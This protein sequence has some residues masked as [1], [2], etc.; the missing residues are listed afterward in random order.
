MF[1]RAEIF[2]RVRALYRTKVYNYMYLIHSFC[3][4]QTKKSEMSV[5]RF[6]FYLKRTNSLKHRLTYP[7]RVHGIKVPRNGKSMRGSQMFFYSYRKPFS[8]VFRWKPAYL[9]SKFGVISEFRGWGAIVFRF[10][11]FY[12][13]FQTYCQS[14]LIYSFPLYIRTP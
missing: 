13:I 6:K 12:F 14:N 4:L 5:L 11:Y 1:I 7:Q 8:Q 10:V 3:I 9:L 2:W